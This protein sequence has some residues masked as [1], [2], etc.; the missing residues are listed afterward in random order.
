MHRLERHLKQKTKKHDQTPPLDPNST[1][2]T[3]RVVHPPPILQWQGGSFNP[4]TEDLALLKD[5]DRRDRKNPLS[6]G[7]FFFTFLSTPVFLTRTKPC[8]SP[9]LSPDLLIICQ[10]PSFLLFFFFFST[11]THTNIRII[12]EKKWKRKK[13]TRI[14]HLTN[15]L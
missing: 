7:N 4:T 9:F 2:S 12:R 14:L 10:L 11:H 3:G 15:D 1:L 13:K 5:P 6:M 8:F